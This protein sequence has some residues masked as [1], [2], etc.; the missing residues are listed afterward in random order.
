[1]MNAH[2][3][4]VVS[5]DSPRPVLAKKAYASPVLYHYG[6]IRDLTMGPSFGTGESG[7]PLT[8]Y[9]PGGQGGWQ[10]PDTSGSLP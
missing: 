6:D 10:P 7:A 2:S 4:H 8:Y 9:A 3:R 5:Q 1:M